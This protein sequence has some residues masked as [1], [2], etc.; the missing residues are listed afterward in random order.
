MLS[1]ARTTRTSTSCRRMRSRTRSS[2]AESSGHVI[3]EISEYS[4]RGRPDGIAGLPRR[5]LRRALTLA[6]VL[7]GEV[8][9][10]L[11]ALDQ[12][13]KRGVQRRRHPN[14]ECFTGDGAAEKIHFRF[15]PMAD[16]GKH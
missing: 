1:G 12:A 4:F 11:F 10:L 5:R 13:I 7:A 16:V 8:P 3:P 2:F 15:R 9:T 6:R 14:A